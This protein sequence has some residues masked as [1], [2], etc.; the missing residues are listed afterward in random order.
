MKLRSR[1]SYYSLVIFSVLFVFTSVIIYTL[2]YR[3]AQQNEYKNL[4]NTTLVSAVYYLEKDEQTHAEHV[5]VQNELQRLIS[6]TNIAVYD[7]TDKQAYGRM[8]QDVLLSPAV[9]AKTRADDYY[10]FESKTDFYAG[11]HYHDN[12]GD[13]VV[14]TRSSKESFN[15][16]MYV[17]LGI[18]SAVFLS[19]LLIILLFSRWL[20]KIAYQPIL[21]I[22]E[23]V[24]TRDH[25]NLT[26][27][28]TIDRSYEEVDELIH[29][30]NRFIKR[31]SQTFNIQKN[32]IDYVSHELRTPIAALLG[33]LEV[34]NQKE[35]SVDEYKTMLKQLDEYIQDL[36]STLDHM[37]LLT[38][39]KT[40][41]DFAPIRI[42]EVLWEVVEHATMYHNAQIEVYMDVQDNHLLEMNGNDKLLELAIN[43][44]VGNAI[45]YSDNQTVYLS[46][47]ENNGHLS[48]RIVDHGIG[49][50][51]ED[52]ERATQNFFRG[53]NTS[54]YQGKGIGLSMASIV[55]SLHGIQMNIAS[56]QAGTTVTLLFSKD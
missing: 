1:L 29:S 35:R 2:F 37:M 27:P 21:R 43:N 14:F 44:L 28:I 19:S 7:S 11:I 22:I 4:Q 55:F 9:L 51:K 42:D 52:L 31:I 38:G 54:A 5:S 32:F 56:G 46:L 25:Q 39:A 24:N 18:L 10:V 48:I 36:Q 13:F 23:Q 40:N 30:Y 50:P 8:E 15:E 34:T 33:T 16:L 41:F 53:Q 17:L 49:I 12:Q 3:W 20:G 26:V 47:H 45:K 6:T